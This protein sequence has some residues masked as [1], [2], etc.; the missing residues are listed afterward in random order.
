[1][2]GGGFYI[3]QCSRP[4]EAFVRGGDL[5][6]LQWSGACRGPVRGG[7]GG[8]LYILQCSEGPDKGS[9]ESCLCL[10]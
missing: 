7:G 1:M 8:G 2:R 4:A 10:Y 5:Y 6:I 3:L 9:F